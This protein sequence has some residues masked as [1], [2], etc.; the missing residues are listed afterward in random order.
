MR[1]RRPGYRSTPAVRNRLLST[2]FRHLPGG[3]I[4]PKHNEL[5][6]LYR[7]RYRM[8]LEEEKYDTALNLLTFTTKR[9]ALDIKKAL[10]DPSADAQ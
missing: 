2:R 5:I 4:D 8:A 1:Q 6:S 7:L 9:A 3:W 10:Y